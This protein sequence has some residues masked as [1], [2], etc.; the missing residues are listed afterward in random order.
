[1]FFKLFF[2][3]ALLTIALAGKPYQVADCNSERGL[4]CALTYRHALKETSKHGYSISH[5][6]ALRKDFCTYQQKKCSKL[7]AEQI[8]DI[9]IACWLQV[10]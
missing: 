5:C 7:T 10:E 1:M 8:D 4:E 9:D 6:E 2:I 3:L